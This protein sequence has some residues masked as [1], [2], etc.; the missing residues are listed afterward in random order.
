MARRGEISRKARHNGELWLEAMSH[1]VRIRTPSFTTARLGSHYG[2]RSPAVRRCAY[3]GNSGG[4]GDAEP[5][6]RG[7]KNPPSGT[8]SGRRGSLGACQGAGVGGGRYG[9]VPLREKGSNKGEWSPVQRQGEDRLARP[10]SFATSI[11][12]ATMLMPHPAKPHAPTKSYTNAHI[13]PLARTHAV[14]APPTSSHSYARS[15]EAVAAVCIIRRTHSLLTPPRVLPLS[16]SHPLSLHNSNPHTSE[17]RHSPR[18]V[19]PPRFQL[20]DTTFSYT[21]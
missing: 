14:E 15:R 1:E 11:V 9:G 19:R 2:L 7:G 17:A 3:S 6:K 20:H 5:S 12:R 4:G 16:N 10:S 21:L 18:S 8:V 13:D